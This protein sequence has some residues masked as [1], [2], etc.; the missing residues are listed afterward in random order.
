MLLFCSCC[1]AVVVVLLLLFCSCCVV[2]NDVIQ[3]FIL[4]LI[5]TIDK[6]KSSFD[7]LKHLP[8]PYCKTTLKAFKINKAL[9][10]PKHAVTIF[11]RA[12]LLNKGSVEWQGQRSASSLKPTWCCKVEMVIQLTCEFSAILIPTTNI[13]T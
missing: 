1:F 2:V 3:Y 11:K 7:C 13:S 4:H 12:V 9:N 6:S 8:R 10:F 5:L